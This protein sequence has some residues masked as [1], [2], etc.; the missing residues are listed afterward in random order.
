MSIYVR[1]A[2]GERILLDTAKA[3]LAFEGREIDLTGATLD[4][5]DFSWLTTPATL[6][7]DAKQAGVV[8]GIRDTFTGLGIEAPFHLEPAEAVAYGLAV[9]AADGRENGRGEKRRLRKLREL[10]P[11]AQ[12]L[13]S[14][15]TAG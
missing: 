13:G 2:E 10:L 11:G 9:A 1:T 15:A 7:E 12:S 5:Y 3:K 8:L 6:G 4:I 14:A